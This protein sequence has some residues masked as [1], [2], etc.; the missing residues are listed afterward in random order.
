[1]PPGRANLICGDPETETQQPCWPHLLSIQ[2]PLAFL[3]PWPCLLLKECPGE[4]T[5]MS[6]SQMRHLG[7]ELGDIAISQGSNPWLPG[8]QASAPGSASKCLEL[9]KQMSITGPSAP[10]WEKMS[11]VIKAMSR[12]LANQRRAVMAVNSSCKPVPVGVTW[13]ISLI[14]YG[15]LGTEEEKRLRKTQSAGR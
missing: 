15:L 9:R 11:H 5:I 13:P 2:V 12:I 10:H 1:M 4:D 3:H 8:F 6:A 14:W 7:S